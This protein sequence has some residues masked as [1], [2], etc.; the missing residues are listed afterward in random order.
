M[1][2]KTCDFKTRK[3]LKFEDYLD[4]TSDYKFDIITLDGFYQMPYVHRW[5]DTY[6]KRVLAK[7]YRFS[8]WYMKHQT[9]ITMLTLTTRQR[10]L[11]HEEQMQLL[12]YSY[13][14]IMK[15]VR[16]IYTANNS[17]VI[18]TYDTPTGRLS[19]KRDITDMPKL[20]YLRILEPHKSGYA[21][22]H[23]LLLAT[24]SKSDMEHISDLWQHK[25]SAGNKYGVDFEHKSQNEIRHPIAYVMK[26]LSKTLQGDTI[27]PGQLLHAATVYYLEH[28]P[29]EHGVR[30]FSSSRG[31]SKIMKLPDER[32]EDEI[33]YME[34]HATSYMVVAT[35]P[36]GEQFVKLEGEYDDVIL[37]KLR[38]L[39][40]LS[41]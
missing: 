12:T 2:L 38:E 5:T 40:K 18:K 20:E 11:S 34:N 14:R 9:P 29:T 23:I 3:I 17:T 35:K 21:H 1:T 24:F 33:E 25:Y 7:L 6:R 27:L 16:R 4:Y 30:L 26:Y 28:E 41:F 15:A 10:E 13:T 37:Q 8:D 32:T 36:D 22:L 19:R 39:Q 31:L